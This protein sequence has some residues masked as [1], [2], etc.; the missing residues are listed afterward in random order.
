MSMLTQYEN[1]SHVRMLL[2]MLVCK[3]FASVSAVLYLMLRF[4]RGAN[5]GALRKGFRQYTNFFS[6]A[7]ETWSA[8]YSADYMAKEQRLTPYRQKRR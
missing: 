3:F 5:R 4:E 1:D 8:L 2:Q 7:A 6:V